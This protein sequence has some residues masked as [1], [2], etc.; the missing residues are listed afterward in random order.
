MRCSPTGVEENNVRFF[1]HPDLPGVKIEVDQ[2][3]KNCFRINIDGQI[4]TPDDMV[5]FQELVTTA[6]TYQSLQ[7]EE[8]PA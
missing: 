1:R 5:L 8:V 4:F 6:L 2:S 3:R 7:G